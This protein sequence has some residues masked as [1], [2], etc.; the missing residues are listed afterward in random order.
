M[1]YSLAW[2]LAL[3]VPATAFAQVTSRQEAVQVRGP[4]AIPGDVVDDVTSVFNSGG[5]RRVSGSL[6]IAAG[7]EIASDLAIVDGTLTIAGRVTGRIVA[8]NADVVLQSTARVERDV[9]ILGGQFH[10]GEGGVVVGDVRVYSDQVELEFQGDRVVIREETQDEQWYRQRERWRTRTWSDLRLVS[11]RTYNRVEG[12]PVLI[13]PAFG[14]DFGWGRL[15]LEALGVLRSVGGF[16]WTSANVG[17]SVKAELRLGHR[18]GLRLG[19]RLFDIV[20]PVEPWHL[21]D[22]EVG[23]A[24]FFLHR[25]YRDYFDR[26][27]ASLHGAVFFGGGADVS[28]AYSDQRWS[29]RTTRDPWTL[30]RDND[31]WRPNPLMDAGKFHIVNTTL[32]YD[33]RNDDRDPW[34]GWHVVA[35]YEYGTGRITDYGPTS[36]FVRTRT[37]DG[38]TRY[39]RAFLD[40]RRYNRV[41]PDGQLNLRLVLG[42]WLSGDELPLQRR[43]SVGGPGTIAGNDFRRFEPGVDYWACSGE[44]VDAIPGVPLYPPGAPAQCERVMLAQ[45]EIR[46]DLRADPFGVLHGERDQRR[47]GWGRRTEWVV[48]ADAG[49]GWLVGPRVGDLQYRDGQFPGLGTFRTDVGIGLRLDDLGLYFAKSLSEHHAPVNFFVR[50][51]P[52]F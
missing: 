34:S 10:P 27:G 29:S 43:F 35:D 41:S 5:V 33:T 21:S 1:R 44:R 12:L 26:H 32:R 18:G 8:V 23:L 3:A 49:R 28:V 13:G 16:D 37:P 38:R 24:S 4:R 31:G 51:K 46:G 7:E 30:F 11:A 19:G 20:E 50:L 22:P 45:V 25:D 14:R 48:F 52:R 17:H 2:L 40:L 15:T 9:T 42:G 6:T 36:P 47:F 39:D